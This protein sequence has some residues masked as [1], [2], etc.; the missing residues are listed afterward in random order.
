[1]FANRGATARSGGS[2]V[3]ALH[4]RLSSPSGFISVGLV[5]SLAVGSAGVALG[6]GASR[7]LMDLGDGASW[8]P[9][10]PAVPSPSSTGTWIDGR[11]LRAPKSVSTG[12]AS[13]VLGGQGV[14]YVLYAENGTVRVLDQTS[15]EPL[16][17]SARRS[18]ARSPTATASR[19]C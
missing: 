15:L 6:Q 13:S 17:T 12:G 16:G 10:N 9:T 8:L 2:A 19:T 11:T 5:V 1:M 18:S 7:V 3:T 4:R 14:A